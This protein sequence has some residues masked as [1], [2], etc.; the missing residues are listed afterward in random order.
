M[1]SDRGKLSGVATDFLTSMAPRLAS[2]FIPLISLYVP[3][4]IKLLARPNKVYLRRAEKSLLTIAQYCPHPSFILIVKSGVDDKSD[5]CR[6]ACGTVLS[7][8]LQEW[9]MATL[10][11]KGLGEVEDAIKRMATERDAEVRKIAK[12]MWEVYNERFADRVVG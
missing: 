7:Y 4:L 5:T 12:G 9:G 11:N 8:V 6:R 3:P 1:L 10:G 2:S